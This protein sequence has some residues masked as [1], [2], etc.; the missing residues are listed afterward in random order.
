MNKF[1]DKDKRF[2]WHPFT[3]M[4]EWFK[5]DIVTIEKGEGCYL[6][7]TKGRRYID[8]VSSLWCNIHGHRVKKIDNVIIAQLRKIAHSTFL[9]LS[10]V[11]AI[12]LAEKL[13]KISPPGLSRVFYSEDGAEAVEIA[14]KIAYQYWRNTGKKRS[15]FLTLTN[16]YHGD[17]I[18]CVS[19]GGIDLFH[20]IYKPLLFDTIRVPP[21]IDAIQMAVKKHK[22]E[23]IAIVVE[24]LIQCAGGMLLQPHGF[25]R[26]LREICSRYKVLLIFDEVATGFGRTGKMFA[27]EHE[28]V[29]PDIMALGKGLT[30]GYLPLAATLTTEEIFSAF[31]GEYENTFFHGH[32]YT[33]N[34]IA[35]SAGIANLEIFEEEGVL[36]KLQRKIAILGRKLDEF[37]KLPSVGDIR[38][39]GFIAGIELCKKKNPYKPYPSQKRTGHRVI[40]QARKNGVIIRPL[41]DIIVLMPPLS[42]SRYDLEIL[43][44]VTYKSIKT[45]TSLY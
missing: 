9:G 18:G 4:Q 27:C 10:N 32:T 44:D 20:R 31:L 7:D 33:A 34:P 23:L 5:E 12:E 38:Q 2:L 36:E 14:I 24:P 26:D 43:L 16:A 28:G 8:G 1:S 42:I 35:C 11:P 40:L 41:G 13:I 19:L 3:Q 29:S 21:D 15:K 6:F 30:G 22:N 37:W 45:V 17:T 39:K 25:L